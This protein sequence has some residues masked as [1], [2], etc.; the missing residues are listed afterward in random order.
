VNTAYKCDS[1]YVCAAAL[2]DHTIVSDD[3][4]TFDEQPVAMNQSTSRSQLIYTEHEHGLLRCVAFGGSPPPDID[5]YVGKQ[6]IT[7][8][9]TQNRSPTITGQRG[10]RLIYYTTEL[11]TDQLQLT[12]DDDG[13]LLRCVVT[14]PGSP[15]VVTS[16]LI[17]VH[18]MPLK[19]HST[20]N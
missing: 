8:S 3:N 5:L 13:A 1:L 19:G 9:M 2:V 20:Q 17:T 4:I 16:A 15:S 6:D 11:S 12:A 7:S 10:L 14:V 18:C